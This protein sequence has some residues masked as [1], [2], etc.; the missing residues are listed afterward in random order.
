MKNGIG[1]QISTS[2]KSRIEVV[3]EQ[4]VKE[5]GQRE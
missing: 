5:I 3:G 2:L 4:V 1:Q